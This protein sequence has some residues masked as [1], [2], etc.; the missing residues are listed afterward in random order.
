MTNTIEQKLASADA[1]LREEAAIELSH[2]LTQ[3]PNITWQRLIEYLDKETEPDVKGALIYAIGKT[4]DNAAIPELASRLE[5][6]EDSELR[7]VLVEALGEIGTEKAIVHLI[8][9]LQKDKEPVWNIRSAAVKALGTIGTDTAI[10]AI[11]TYGE[12][13]DE[14]F[15][16]N[17]T[18]YWLDRQGIIQAT[19]IES[20]INIEFEKLEINQ[21]NP[22][23][24]VPLFADN[25]WVPRDILQRMIDRGLSLR[26][27]QAQI[28]EYKRMEFRR[29]LI[30]SPQ[31][32]INRAYLYNEKVLYEN[33]SRSGKEREAFK[34]LL[35][36]SV[37]V[38]FLLSEET[39]LQ[40]P[41]F[42][43]SSFEEWS[44]VCQETQMKCVRLSWD[45]DENKEQI[46]E[47]MIRPFHDF[48]ATIHTGNIERYM[49]DL[50]LS[51]SDREPFKKQLIAIRNKCNELED[52]EQQVTREELYKAFVTVEG[53]QVVDG[54][55]D[56]RKPFSSAIKQLLDLKYNINLPD[57]LQGFALTPYDSLSRS[58]LQENK[59]KS[60]RDRSQDKNADTW[61]KLLRN[62][63]FEKLQKGLYL[64][65]NLQQGYLDSLSSLKLSEVLEVRAMDEWTQY[66]N[67][68]DTLLE[69]PEKFEEMS[70]K[71]YLDY[72]NLNKVITNLVTQNR[73]QEPVAKWTPGIE[74]ILEMA[75]ARM[76][77]KWS[78]E[79]VTYALDGK[80]SSNLAKKQVP[81]IEKMRIAG[82]EVNQADL[83]TTI[84]I[85]KG[86]TSAP[87]EQW[88]FLSRKIP[89]EIK[90]IQPAKAT[91]ENDATL[92]LPG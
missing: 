85:Q 52:R 1:N 49:R 61:L 34:E 62:S 43:T 73:S 40:S 35:N 7:W 88:E 63:T 67:S 57:A 70:D 76:S 23:H 48:A 32:A 42:T 69:D 91:V 9:H 18:K 87:G 8:G 66:M 24:T 47:Y 3:Y 29:S 84:E 51:E 36:S 75:G 83:N 74:Y 60:R 26:D 68:I 31:I 11:K 5:K 20:S 44:K 80:V 22:Y 79:G 15:V 53:S 33:F 10:D 56:R 2:S 45:D 25:Q 12:K 28:E 59:P 41:N 38:P 64:E 72:L 37:I 55:Y 19:S 17:E 77:V 89:K 13:D 27:V 90:G 14:F 86:F 6:E 92:N 71:V 39:P 58:V 81:Y 21:L 82:L 4:R 65:S 50:G 16:R 78:H 46:E 54:I 30:N